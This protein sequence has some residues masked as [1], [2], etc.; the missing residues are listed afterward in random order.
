MTSNFDIEGVK[1][2]SKAIKNK[3]MENPDN[4]VAKLQM[5]DLVV[6]LYDVFGMLDKAVDEIADLRSKQKGTEEEL[7]A[8]KE[9][10]K[11]RIYDLEMKNLECN[12][13]IKNADLRA[14]DGEKEKGEDSARIAE[15]IFEA[16]GVSDTVKAASVIRFEKSKK[17]ES[18]R[19]PILL[20]KLKDAK[21][22]SKI[23]RN[24]AKLSDSK[25]K[26]ISI[27]NQYPAA[28]RPEM[29]KLMRIGNAIREESNK[30]TKFRVSVEKG[31]P[32]LKLKEEGDT[33]FKTL[34]RIPEKFQ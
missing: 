12:L 24:V 4:K 2:R 25:F 7:K 21:M 19:P 27:S 16:I 29:S 6:A 17:Y 28:L 31:K 18:K 23:F 33:E 20:I 32:V 10:E 15:E 30:K 9:D 13:M 34:E 11:A 26:E 3:I 14:K 5:A 1:K 8:S 22:K